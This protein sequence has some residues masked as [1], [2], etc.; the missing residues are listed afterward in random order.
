MP[1]LVPCRLTP[2]LVA[3]LGAT[4]VEGKFRISCEQ[5]LA[6][7]RSGSDVVLGLLEAFVYDPLMDWSSDTA[8]ALA[9]RR[10]LDASVLA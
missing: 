6:A 3:G 7:L 4:A 2:L 1:E 10:R 5:T 9:A 8:L